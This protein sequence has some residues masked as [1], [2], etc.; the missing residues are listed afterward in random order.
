M[1]RILWPAIF[2]QKL[3]FIKFYSVPRISLITVYKIQ[4][5][6]YET[7]H[8]QCM[9]FSLMKWV[10][11]LQYLLTLRTRQRNYMLITMAKI[12]QTSSQRKTLCR[13]SSRH[14]LIYCSQQAVRGLRGRQAPRRPRIV[15]LID[16]QSR[17]PKRLTKLILLESSLTTGEKYKVECGRDS[18]LSKKVG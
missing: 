4:L 14:C 11:I 9:Y 5:L 13:G 1:T 18:L 17:L 10:F 7:V 15:G 3:F 8:P 16:G 6:G 12:Y 2:K